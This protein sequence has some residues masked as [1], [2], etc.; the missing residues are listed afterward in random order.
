MAVILLRGDMKFC[1]LFSS[2]LVGTIGLI[3]LV[4]WHLHAPLVVQLHPSFVPMQY[5]TALC[6]ALVGLAIFAIFNGWRRVSVCSATVVATVGLL[7]LFEYVTGVSLGIDELLM[8]HDITVGS[9]HPG[10]MAPNT[11][12]CFSLTS[13][14]VFYLCRKTEALHSVAALVASL[15]FALAIVA[16]VG[17]LIDLP[18]AYGWGQLTR[19]ALHTG[20]AFLI[21]S[22]A[23]VVWCWQK[24]NRKLPS[25]S[26]AVVAIAMLTI[27]VVAAQS[28]VAQGDAKKIT[29]ASGY[30]LTLE[31]R[32]SELTLALDRMARRQSRQS[33]DLKNQPLGGKNWQDDA[34]WYREHFDTLQGLSI[35]D[36]DGNTAEST[37]A[38][39]AAKTSSPPK[40]LVQL[41]DG[42][43]SSVASAVDEEGRFLILN[44]I[45]SNEKLVAVLVAQCD[46][47][48]FIEGTPSLLDAFNVEL[49]NEKHSNFK[50]L[51]TTIQTAN[52]SVPVSLIPKEFSR[53]NR[54]VA[55]CV[56]VLSILSALVLFFFVKSR[57][58]IEN[59]NTQLGK[60]LGETKSVNSELRQKQIELEK[61]MNTMQ[62][63]ADSLNLSN[64]EL[65][66]FAYV[67]AHDLRSPLRVLSNLSTFITE[68]MD[69]VD[70]N[71]PTS[72][73][74]SLGK[75][76]AQVERM[77][78]LLSGLLDFAR[79]GREHE[80][81]TELNVD[82]VISEAILLAGV[83]STFV[84]NRT[85]SN[86]TI[87]ASENS[88]LRVMQNL[89][90][91]A[92]KHHSGESGRIDIKIENEADSILISVADDGSGIPENRY[93]K[94]FEIFRTLKPKQKSSTGIGL[95]IV[96]K[97][98][99]NQGGKIW[100]EPSQTGG[101]T[102]KMRFP[103]KSVELPDSRLE[104]VLIHDSVATSGN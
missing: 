75:L 25:W 99:T 36:F 80:A 45:T 3:V 15:V 89:I 44:P 52:I 5:N 102:F 33:K 78:S 69:E 29:E 35:V 93:D 51:N 24:E 31:H 103:K 60:A 62:A 70:I 43:N 72:V 95:A 58:K 30:Q 100:I 90:D 9:S 55:P 88:L 19:M 63:Y 79:V 83:P 7:T 10:R 86:L 96:K 39:P 4:G 54:V 73:E 101:A 26:P 84:V 23:L 2:L 14:S 11:A 66:D 34:K 8:T 56:I 42:G 17:Y 21:S 46:F 6:F 13:L 59:I 82:K 41:L 97:L 22:F 12:L 76:E 20:I 32:M 74:D 92:V 81:P 91:N 57:I 67:A 68:D 50:G 49:G 87:E 104:E 61:T 40:E 18:T 28:I 38:L 77:D 65:Q 48:A 85:D 47:N 16:A 71:L 27:G 37:N 64:Q 94:V 53:T 98:V 1:V